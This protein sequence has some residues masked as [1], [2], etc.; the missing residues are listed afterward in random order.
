LQVL[1]TPEVFVPQFDPTLV[2]E[3][4]IRPGDVIFVNQTGYFITRDY[5]ELP[6]SNE[7]PNDLIAMEGHTIDQVLTLLFIPRRYLV[8]P[9]E[10]GEVIN[11]P[12]LDEME[13]EEDEDAEGDVDVGEDM[14]I[15]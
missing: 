8:P 5:G 7:F 6:N 13:D 4:R 12:H 1:N 10:F 3:Q 15:D 11:G 9:E 2:G 14:A